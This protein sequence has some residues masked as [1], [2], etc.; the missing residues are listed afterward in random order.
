MKEDMMKV[1]KEMRKKILKKMVIMVKD[2]MR[3]EEVL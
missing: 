2:E 1:E 3:K